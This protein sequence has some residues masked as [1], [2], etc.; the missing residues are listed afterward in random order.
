MINILNN[1]KEHLTTFPAGLICNALPA[2]IKA[3]LRPYNDGSTVFKSFDRV[4]H[5][6]DYIDTL[7]EYQNA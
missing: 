7:T 5:M 1:A 2:D 4:G 6:I 3:L